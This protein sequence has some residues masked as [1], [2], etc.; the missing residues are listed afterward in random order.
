M[1]RT[2]IVIN[3]ARKTPD[4]PPLSLAGSILSATTEACSFG[5]M[6]ARVRLRW[7][8]TQKTKPFRTFPK[9]KPESVIEVNGEVR[10]RDE[11]TENANLDTGDI[12]LFA[13]IIDN[14]SKTPP[15]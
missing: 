2:I 9:L 4:L 1:K 13:T 11:G 12:E 10:K 6:T 15:F 7:Y 14:Q 5:S 8:L 3:Y